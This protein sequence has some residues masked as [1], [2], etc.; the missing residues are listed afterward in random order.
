M[1]GDDQIRV[2]REVL[3]FLCQAT[4]NSPTRGVS[5]DLLKEYSWSEPLHRVV[6]EILASFPSPNPSMLRGQLPTLLTRRGFPDVDWED[7]FNPHSLSD[8][9]FSI[10]VRQMTGKAPTFS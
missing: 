2:E 3:R 7:F 5:R 6:F 8:E 1:K 10:L 4:E 9:Q